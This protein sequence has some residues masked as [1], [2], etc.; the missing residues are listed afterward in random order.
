MAP[1]NAK[2]TKHD[3]QRASD[4]AFMERE[5][6]TAVPLVLYEYVD[7]K[8]LCYL[9]DNFDKLTAEWEEL[10]PD[11]KEVNQKELLIS[12]LNNIDSDGKIE[13][14]YHPAKGKHHGRLFA[15]PS[16]QLMWCPLRHTLARDHYVDID[17]KNAHPTLLKQYCDKHGIECT[18]LSYYINQRD[19]VLSNVISS[20]GL[21]G[22][23][24]RDF[25]KCK[26]MLA[27]M[28]GGGWRY[29][30]NSTFL[31]DYYD[32]LKD[33]REAIMEMHPSLVKIAESNKDKKYNKSGSVLNQLLCV[34]ENKCIHS[35]IE[36]MQSKGFEVGTDVFDGC[37]VRKNGDQQITQALLDECSEHVQHETGYA[38]EL[39][40]K[41]MDKGFHPTDEDLEKASTSMAPSIIL[42][43]ILSKHGGDAHYAEYYLH[44]HPSL[45]YT[46]M[47]GFIGFST[48]KCR[49]LK[50]DNSMI[51][52]QIRSTLNTPLYG[53]LKTWKHNLKEIQK[54]IASFGDEQDAPPE[55]KMKAKVASGK[56]E[57]AE[58]RIKY[59]NQM[60]GVE[61]IRKAV[62]DQCKDYELDEKLDANPYILGTD[63]G[64]IDVKTGEYRVQTADDY[65]MMSV[66]YKYDTSDDMLRQDFHTYLKQT[67][68]NEEVRHMMQQIAY[69]TLHGD[70]PLKVAFLFMDKRRGNNGKSKAQKMVRIAVGE[71]ASCKLKSIILKNDKNKNPNAPDPGIITFR[72]MRVGTCEELDPNDK[73]DLTT[74]KE[75][76]GN[77]TP[78]SGRPLYKSHD[79]TFPWTAKMILSMNQGNMSQFNAT[80]GV[81]VDRLIIIPFESK[82][83]TKGKEGTP[84]RIEYETEI[85]EHP[86]TTFIENSDIDIDL[87]NWRPY[88]L[89]WALQARDTFDKFK[90]IPDI[91]GMWKDE[92]VEENNVVKQFIKAYVTKAEPKTQTR[93]DETKRINVNIEIPANRIYFTLP[94]AWGKFN[95]VNSGSAGL[96]RTQFDKLLI[97][98]FKPDPHTET[99]YHSYTTRTITEE[100]KDKRVGNAVWGYQLV[101]E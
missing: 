32:E 29:R 61:S 49:W 88:Y 64:V 63:G 46:D 59:L 98:E 76:N 22:R 19:D 9:I 2:R 94:R 47:H 41:C 96:R 57:L 11:K 15:N 38:I 50:H 18:H 31:R 73:L 28:N 79:I 100:E 34:L 83:V 37:M 60:N 85:A 92:V 91:C 67:F 43:E 53:E 5:K 13:V 71:Y 27:I 69:Y 7:K 95:S 36:F 4:E 25:A 77:N 14:S 42:K 23:G 8:M 58:Q 16:F 52:N 72:R 97:D 99:G 1:Y 30:N 12:Y 65:V 68:P 35:V 33:I 74:I 66:G 86:D 101:D 62:I 87:N 54:E 93:W 89:E 45:R 48:D 20:C 70:H 26:I 78:V 40:I 90:N 75:Y 44:H 80:D 56:V 6:H 84:K 82:F 10:D 81:G 51:Q 3:K 21:V 24:A 55:L 17:I 39:V